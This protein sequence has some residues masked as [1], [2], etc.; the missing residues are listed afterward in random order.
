MSDDNS[1]VFGLNRQARS[2]ASIYGPPDVSQFVVGTIGLD[3][4]NSILIQTGYGN[5]NS[6]TEEL[7]DSNSNLLPSN[8]TSIKLEEPVKFPAQNDFEIQKTICDKNTLNA[9]RFV[10]L[11]H[12]S[13]S[14]FTFSNSGEITNLSTPFSAV[15]IL[16]RDISCS[17]IYL[18][19]VKFADNG[20][21]VLVAASDG[22]LYGSDTRIN[23]SRHISP[24]SISASANTSSIV[25]TFWNCNATTI[26][27]NPN[28]PHQV[29]TGSEDGLVRIF[30]L[31]YFTLPITSIPPT[32]PLKSKITNSNSNSFNQRNLAGHKTSNISGIFDSKN[33]IQSPSAPLLLELSEGQHSHFVCDLEYNPLYDEL[34]LSSGS[35]SIVNL[36]SIKSVSSSRESSDLKPNVIDDFF[37]IGSTDNEV[38]SSNIYRKGSYLHSAESYSEISS[39]KHHINS[40]SSHFYENKPLNGYDNNS[41]VDTPL[42]TE[43][44]FSFFN[45]DDNT[46]PLNKKE[47]QNTSHFDQLGESDSYVVSQHDSHELSVYKCCWSKNNPWMFAS[48]SLDGRVVI[49]YV[50]QPEKFKILSQN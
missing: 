22:N 36:H 23:S 42:S 35:D 14:L 43:Q 28:L 32:S 49:N 27:T 19:D 6:D 18:N 46:N 24:F 2:M 13:I 44:S 30:D 7:L 12:S 37:N 34:I 11:S 38:E 39:D 25:N 9:N 20:N 40:S 1:F 29:A 48:L 8:S 47:N 16:S 5:E 31:R 45:D 4:K 3:R 21:L 26:D 41:V 17:E 50:P 15:N 33:L 10:T